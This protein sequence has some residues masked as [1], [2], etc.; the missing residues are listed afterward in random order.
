[1]ALY[2]SQLLNTK[3]HSYHAYALHYTRTLM[4]WNITEII[5]HSTGTLY[6]HTAGWWLPA[7]H[8]D[9]LLT[10]LSVQHFHMRG[11]KNSHKSEWSIFHCCWTATVEQLTVPLHL[12]D[13]GIPPAAE[14]AQVCLPGNCRTQWLLLFL[15]RVYLMYLLTPTWHVSQQP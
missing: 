15:E 10:T 5:R 6:Q 14:D 4:T 7:C 12:R 13:S 1:M 3:T 8:N 2:G 9:Q 11:S